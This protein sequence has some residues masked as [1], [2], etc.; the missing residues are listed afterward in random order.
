MKYT[1][2]AVALVLLVGAGILGPIRQSGADDRQALVIGG[3]VSPSQWHDALG[4]YSE[5]WDVTVT[6]RYGNEV[7]DTWSG[8]TYE[9]GL[10]QR[11]LHQDPTRSG[12]ILEVTVNGGFVYC[13]HTVQVKLDDPQSGSDTVPA[14][15]LGKLI[16]QRHC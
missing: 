3:Q 13:S 11:A 10:F 8:H 12:A 6:L 2:A 16:M 15:D 14:I 5:C 9:A 1:A 4:V 7:Y